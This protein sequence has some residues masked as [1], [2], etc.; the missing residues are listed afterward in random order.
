MVLLLLLLLL[1]LPM[2]CTPMPHLIQLGLKRCN[3]VIFHQ[4]LAPEMF[5]NLV[6][7]P[8]RSLQLLHQGCV[9]C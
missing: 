3:T 5:S 6:V 4:H 8:L 2:Q 7:V 1:L 9:V